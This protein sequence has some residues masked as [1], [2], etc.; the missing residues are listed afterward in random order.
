MAGNAGREVFRWNARGDV[1]DSGL[2]GRV[3]Y[4]SR[5]REHR[6]RRHPGDRRPLHPPHL[7]RGAGGF[8][9]PRRRDHRRGPTRL[10][11]CA[12]CPQ[13]RALPRGRRR[14]RL[15]RCGRRGAPGRPRPDPHG[16]HAGPAAH[17]A[18]RLLRRLAARQGTS[19]C[20]A[21]CCTTTCARRRGPAERSTASGPCA[22][23]TSS[24][25]AAS[26]ARDT[27]TRRSRTSSWATGSRRPRRSDSI[28]RSRAPTS[29]G[30][31]CARCC[32]PTSPA[33][34][35]RGSHSSSA[36]AGSPPRSTA[37][38]DTG[39][40]RWCARSRRSRCSPEP[41]GRRSRSVARSSPSTTPSTHC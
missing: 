16:L 36:R 7:P 1:S 21:T 19:P 11:V 34:G 37:A 6:E 38:G 14:A 18:A 35:R 13:R 24:T 9:G 3:T 40:A 28:R 5:H 4:H 27:P 15:R 2:L 26:T 10:P 20:S 33:E 22:E 17:R 31:R 29:S 39:S 30:G 32:G 12:R 25:S 8:D 41:S 23:R